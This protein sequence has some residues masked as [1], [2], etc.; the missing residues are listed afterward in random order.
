VKEKRESVKEKRRGKRR[1]VR[2]GKK[3]NNTEKIKVVDVEN[4]T[5]L[6]VVLVYKTL[7]LACTDR[8]EIKLLNMLQMSTVG[9][10]S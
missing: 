3:I 9:S 4:P 6:L 1:E 10:R 5:Q 7:S 8:L 2:R